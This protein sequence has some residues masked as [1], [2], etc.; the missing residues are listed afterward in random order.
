M[1]SDPNFLRYRQL[2]ERSYQRLGE[3]RSEVDAW[4]DK[5]AIDMPSLSEI[6]RLEALSAERT[7]LLA[8]FVEAEEHFIDQALRRRQGGQS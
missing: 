5:Y 6:A 1:E 2:R 8:D 4:I 3:I 7:R